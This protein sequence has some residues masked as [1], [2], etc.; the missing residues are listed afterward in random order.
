V[1]YSDTDSVFI[2]SPHDELE[3]SLEFGKKLAAR[4]STGSSVLEFEK[5]FGSFFTHGKKKRYVGKTAWPEEKMIVRG[6]ETRRTDAFDLQSKALTDMFELILS[7]DERGALDYAREIIS[8]CRSGNVK[9]EELVISRSIQ[10]VD[11]EKI[12]QTYKNPDSMANVQALRKS[13]ALGM[14][15][16]PGM[17][18]SWIVTDAK[19]Q[20][21]QV[22]PY[23]DGR[24]FKKTPD[25]GYY[26]ERLASTLSRLTDVFGVGEK[27]LLTGVQQS[28]LFDD[29]GS[30]TPEDQTVKKKSDES[31]EGR[32]DRDVGNST[33][34]KWM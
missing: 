12:R 7:G 33:L 25:Y 26:A 3:G 1:V 11:E 34:D 5:V 2:Q 18:I 19:R 4:F 32:P 23:V 30:E 17:K 13:R 31:D 10:E 27:E 9:D 8:R 24:E 28:S 16:V 29:F 15:V 21:Q 22:E 20:P 6:Y 14:E